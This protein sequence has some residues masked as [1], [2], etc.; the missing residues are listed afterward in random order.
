MEILKTR[1]DVAP[2]AGTSVTFK[3]GISF[4]GLVYSLAGLST[5][6]SFS[7]S[8]TAPPSG[9]TTKVASESG[10]V[11]IYIWLD[12]TALLWYTEA[13]VTY[14]NQNASGMFL[15]LSSATS[16][17]LDGISS[18][19]TSDMSAM[20]AGCE[21]LRTILVSDAFVTTSLT[22]SIGMFNDCSRLVGGAGTAYDYRHTDGTYA[23]I[24]NPPTAPGYFTEAT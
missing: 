17:N 9:F 11:P 1:R 18:L 10:S 13:R 8:A 3:E 5:P 2:P 12:G 14:L 7:R 6:T 15:S 22:S 23:R 24:D 4:N 19:K 20:F 16:I 21:S